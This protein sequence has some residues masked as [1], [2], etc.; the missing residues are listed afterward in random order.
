MYRAKAAPPTSSQDVV[1]FGKYP[2]YVV[3]QSIW[4]IAVS[5]SCII[6][7]NF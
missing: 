4:V 2:G 5:F 7:Y 6:I 3:F 1:D